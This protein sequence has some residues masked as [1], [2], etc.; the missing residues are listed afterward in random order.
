MKLSAFDQV[1]MDRCFI[2]EVHRLY[3][4]GAFTSFNEFTTT[5]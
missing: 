3:E 2:A 5:M 1:A 4:E